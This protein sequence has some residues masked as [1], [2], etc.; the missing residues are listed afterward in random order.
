M[1]H[2][3]QRHKLQTAEEF[4]LEAEQSLKECPSSYVLKSTVLFN[5]ALLRATRLE[6]RQSEL[7][8]KESA[9]LRIQWFGEKHNLVANVLI[10]LAIV[11]ST[12][13]NVQGLHLGRHSRLPLDRNSRLP[14]DRNSRLHIGRQSRLHLGSTL[15]CTLAATVDCTLAATLDCTLAATLD[16]TLAATLDCTLA[17]L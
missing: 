1:A 3:E 9:K 8:L 10:S 5:L 11:L 4:L 14:L 2:R 13:G 17:P 7:L 6:Y 12:P 16:C 15:D